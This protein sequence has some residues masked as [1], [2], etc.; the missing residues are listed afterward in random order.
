MFTFSCDRIS[1]KE[2]E[3]EQTNVTWLTFQKQLSDLQTEIAAEQEKLISK[4]QLKS[5]GMSQSSSQE[6]IDQTDASQSKE[7]LSRYR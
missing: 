2:A 6:T 1:T 7:Q 3:L 5:L 4:D